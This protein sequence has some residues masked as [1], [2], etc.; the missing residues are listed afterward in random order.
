MKQKNK[1]GG[2]KKTVGLTFGHVLAIINKYVKEWHFISRRLYLAS[3]TCS[4]QGEELSYLEGALSRA[5]APPHWEKPAEGTEPN[6][7]AGLERP[8]V[9]SSRP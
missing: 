9:Q 6:L 5:T 7:W 4:R 2:R 1:H 8:G 3:W